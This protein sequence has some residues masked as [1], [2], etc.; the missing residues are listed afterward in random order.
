MSKRTDWS[1]AVLEL[2]YREW[3]ALKNKTDGHGAICPCPECSKRRRLARDLNLPHTGLP[4]F[5]RKKELF[6]EDVSA[7]TTTDS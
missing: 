2:N 4:R 5:M 3:R 6:G 7:Q 1:Q